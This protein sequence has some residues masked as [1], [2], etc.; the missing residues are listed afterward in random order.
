MEAKTIQNSIIAISD[1]PLY[2]LGIDPDINKSGYSCWDS[3][4]KKL[5]RITNL[6][7]WDIIEDLNSYRCPIHVVIEAGWLINKS[8]FHKSQGQFQREKIA[9]NVGQN[10]QIGILIAEYCKR[11]SISYELVK[12]KGK[13]K[14]EAFKH[15]TKW[16]ER[17]NQDSRDA[18]MLVFGW[19]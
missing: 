13:L 8:N 4:K 7:F 2:I 11:N 15:L 18:A 6:S 14:K 1:K 19:N 17:T 5:D 9:K 3:N 10:H 16:D 12:P